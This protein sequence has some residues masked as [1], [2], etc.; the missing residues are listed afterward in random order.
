[1]EK[2]FC[3]LK[4]LISGKKTR[5]LE[6]FATLHWLIKMVKSSKK[7]SILK[8]KE[9]K[10]ASESDIKKSFNFLEKYEKLRKN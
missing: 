9:L 10:D 3:I 2:R 7:E 8:L 5:E 1:M 6:L 4:K